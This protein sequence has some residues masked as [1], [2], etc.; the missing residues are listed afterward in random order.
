[1]EGTALVLSSHQMN[2]VEEL[3]DEVVMI[4]NGTVVL[5]GSLPDIR[6]RYRGDALRIVCAPWPDT[7]QGV[8]EVRREGRGHVMRLL[9]GT[10]PDSVLQQLIAQGCS[11]EHFEVAV[12]SMEEIFVG[13]VRGNYE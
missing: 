8:T 11:V 3:C 9:P 13:V 6:Q 10:S 12:P 1:Q 4:N 7:V 5:S 2:T